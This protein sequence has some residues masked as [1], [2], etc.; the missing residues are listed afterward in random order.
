MGGQPEIV[1][2]PIRKDMVDNITPSQAD[3]IV[4]SSCSRFNEVRFD[5]PDNR[6]GFENSRYLTVSLVDGTWYRGVMARTA[7]VDAGP[8]ADPIGVAYGGETYWHERGYSADGAPLSWSLETGELY[9]SEGNTMMVRGLWPDVTDQRG[10]WNLTLYSR[11]RP[12]GDARTFGPYAIAATTDK[13]DIR[14]SGRLFRI[15]LSGSSSPASGRLGRP[16]FDITKS[17]ER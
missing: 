15:R 3:K 2:C 4:A 17:G 16:V 8:S 6:D 7:M 13:V 10:A 1:E 5:Y 14:A 11:L 12:Q 9:M